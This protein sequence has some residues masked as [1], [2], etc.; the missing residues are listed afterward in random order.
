MTPASTPT[1]PAIAASGLT[2]QFG[3]LRALDNLTLD[4]PRVPSSG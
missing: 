4:I 2:K 1:T 3:K